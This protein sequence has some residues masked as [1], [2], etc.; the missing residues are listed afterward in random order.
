MTWQRA[1]TKADPFQKSEKNGKGRAMM[2]TDERV[3]QLKK[4][5]ADPRIEWSFAQIAE[6]LGG[7]LSRNAVIGKAHRLGLERRKTGT[8]PKAVKAPRNSLGIGAAVQKIAPEPFAITCVEVVPL[9]LTI[10]DLQEGDCRYPYGD[11]P[12]T[13]TYCGHPALFGHSWCAPHFRVVNRPTPPRKPPAP[14]VGPAYSAPSHL[15][16]RGADA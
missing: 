5:Y 9:N 11:D 1:C 7:G 6:K 16:A 2:W 12:A 4:L 14:S 13:M 8:K 3:E 10:M 15:G